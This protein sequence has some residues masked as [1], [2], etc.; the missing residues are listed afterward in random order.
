MVRAMA[1]E[2][3]VLSLAEVEHRVKLEPK[4]ALIHLLQMVEQIVPVREVERSRG[5]VNFRVEF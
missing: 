5:V 3:V 2:E 1:H 4:H